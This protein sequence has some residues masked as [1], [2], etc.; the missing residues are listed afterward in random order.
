MK[1]LD[2]MRH[3]KTEPWSARCDDHERQLT[4]RGLRDAS[5]IGNFLVGSGRMPQ[6]AIVS[7]AK[8]TR[9]TFQR[10][11]ECGLATSAEVADSLYGATANGALS[12]IQGVDN[13]VDHAMVVGHEPTMGDIIGLFISAPRAHLEMPTGVLCRLSFDV[14]VWES[15][16]RGGAALEW[17]IRP[18]VLRGAGRSPQ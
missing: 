1:I 11:S 7:S 13:A 5:L 14:D 8:R 10:L 2:V 15:V 4:Q 6:V 17:L 3:A 16:Y 9:Q 18:S 12:L